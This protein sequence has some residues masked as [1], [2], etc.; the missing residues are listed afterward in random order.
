[1]FSLPA[2]SAGPKRSLKTSRL[3][4]LQVFL[5]ESCRVPPVKYDSQYNHTAHGPHA[6]HICLWETLPKLPDV[7]TYKAKSLEDINCLFLSIYTE[8]DLYL[9]HPEKN[10]G[11]YAVYSSE[12][13]ENSKQ[14]NQR[15]PG[16][17]KATLPLCHVSGFI[18]VTQMLECSKS[19]SRRALTA[20][21]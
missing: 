20:S 12:I 21:Y 8:T 13:M 2:F 5:W 11:E 7:P 18:V 15:P 17:P 14:R 1:M 16:V 6:S 10:K 19:Y 4:Q 3:L 9:P